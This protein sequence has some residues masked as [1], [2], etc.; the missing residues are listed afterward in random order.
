MFESPI[1]PAHRKVFSPTKFQIFFLSFIVNFPE[2]FF[3]KLSA[4]YLVGK[5]ENFQPDRKIVI[6]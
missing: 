4:L 3:T 5:A 1:R 6:K 2:H